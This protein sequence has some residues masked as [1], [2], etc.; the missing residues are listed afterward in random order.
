MKEIQ[1]TNFGT[2]E[3]VRVDEAISETDPATLNKQK[4]RRL[5]TLAVRRNVGINQGQVHEGYAGT[6]T[7]TIDTNPEKGGANVL[8]L[9]REMLAQRATIKRL[10][11]ELSTKEHEIRRYAERQIDLIRE[12]VKHR[13]DLE[14]HDIHFTDY[15]NEKTQ[16]QLSEMSRIND[17]KEDDERE[18]FH[19]GNLSKNMFAILLAD[20]ALLEERYNR[21]QTESMQRIF[22]LE[23]ENDRLYAHISVLESAS[24]DENTV[25]TMHDEPTDKVN[26]ERCRNLEKRNALLERQQTKMRERIRT[27]EMDQRGNTGKHPDLQGS[28]EVF[29]DN[30]TPESLIKKLQNDLTRKQQKIGILRSEAILAQA[31]TMLYSFN[32]EQTNLHG[33]HGSAPKAAS[34]ELQKLKRLMETKKAK[35]A[36]LKRRYKAREASLLL[37]L[38]AAH[39]PRGRTVKHCRDYFL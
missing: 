36:E 30:E 35:N 13:I 12:L 24:R 31:N 38:E 23:S 16:Y 9:Q 21:D 10:Q 2:G 34:S 4:L 39:L 22:L 7:T 33:K 11:N 18:G 27:L 5:E 19:V 25:N 14:T 32:D 37:Q 15:L 26:L 6:Q 28:T 1:R 8:A 17:E 20:F 29:T 3:S